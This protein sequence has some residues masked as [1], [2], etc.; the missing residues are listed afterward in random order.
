MLSFA[1]MRTYLG[2]A[3][4]KVMDVRSSGSLNDLIIGNRAMMGAVTN[5]IRN[6]NVK[7]HRLLSH[8]SDL[9]TKPAYVEPRN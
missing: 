3:L 6:R 9:G 5:V 1:A 4:H 8:D 7:Q 2:Q